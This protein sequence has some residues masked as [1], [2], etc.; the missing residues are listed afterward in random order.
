VLFLCVQSQG[1]TSEPGY[2]VSPSIVGLW[3]WSGIFIPAG[4]APLPEEQPYQPSVSL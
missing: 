2:N 4:Q 1:W 3:D